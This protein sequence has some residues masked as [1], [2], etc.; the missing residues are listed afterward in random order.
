MDKEKIILIGCGEHAGMVID[1]IEEQDKY[2]LFGL[3]TNREE[4]LGK[5]IYGYSVVCKDDEIKNLLNKNTD[6]KGYVLGI[7]NMK[8]RTKIFK[9]LDNFLIPVNIIHP[10]AAISKHAQIGKGNV[11][12]AYTKIA[13]GSKIGNHCIINSFSAINHNQV[14]GD[15]VLIAGNVSMAGKTI[16]DSTIIADGA[17]IGF[18]KS[19]GS[20]CIVGDGAVV[21]KDIPDNV[22]VYGNPARI[23]RKND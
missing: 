16:G 6:I 17:S 9:L 23:I 1:N 11:I 4:E 21:T 12:E 2:E 5:K 8:V 7:G 20:N 19:V 13:N 15:N 10:T 14:I 22:I 3:V 18:K